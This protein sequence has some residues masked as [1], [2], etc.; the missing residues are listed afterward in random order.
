MA[1]AIL[2]VVGGY[3]VMALIVFGTFTVAYL[4]MGAD[5]AY[6]PGTYDV[7]L[8]W[9]VVSLV[10][11]AVAAVAGG[12]IAVAIAGS[13]VPPKI[14]AGLVL[15]LGLMMAYMDAGRM[16]AQSNVR[17]ASLSFMDAA[18]AS[19]QPTWLLYLNPLIGAA[20]VLIG[21]GMGRKKD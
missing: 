20:G 12:R 8:L 9:I 21:A 15:V 5:S 19:R 11:S 16:A 18:Q 6:Q 2:S 1:R 14:L 4:L 7:S 17:E 13:D 10:F 3:V